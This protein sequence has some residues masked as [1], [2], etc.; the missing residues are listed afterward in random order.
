MLTNQEIAKRLHQ[1]CGPL[2]GGRGVSC[3]RSMILYLKRDN[4]LEDARAVFATDGDKL[5]QYPGIY[6]KVTELLGCRLHGKNL[7]NTCYL[8]D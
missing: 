6:N 3:V 5:Y 1:L 2:N 8:P 7:C 4:S